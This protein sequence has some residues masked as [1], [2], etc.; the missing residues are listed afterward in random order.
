MREHVIDFGRQHVITK[1]TVSIDIDALVVMTAS[2]LCTHFVQYYQITDPELA[3]FKI[4]NLP[5]SIEL[6]TQTTL[7][8]I[9]AQM[10]LD[11]TFS[12]RELINV[13]AFMKFY[14]LHLGT[15]ERKDD[16]R[17]RALGCFHQKS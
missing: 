15:A 14:S 16:D 7:R 10:T 5:D 8:N 13:R 12:S 2:E 4:Q 6:L 17:R 11:D 3:V 9:I 1:D